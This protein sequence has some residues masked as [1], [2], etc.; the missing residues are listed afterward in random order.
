MEEFLRFV[1]GQLVEFPDELVI[2][3]ADEEDKSTFHV[4][5]RKA[6]IPKIIGKNGHTIEAIRTLLSASAQKR[7]TRVAVEIIE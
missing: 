4:A 6:D 3:C 2:S 5:A 1:L 7:G